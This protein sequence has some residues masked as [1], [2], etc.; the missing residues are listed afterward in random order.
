MKSYYSH[1]KD[2]K[3]YTEQVNKITQGS[4]NDKRLQHIHIEL[5]I[6]RSGSGKTNALSQF[7]KQQVRN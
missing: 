4:N 6:G 7:N 3:V 5:R 1:N 2:L